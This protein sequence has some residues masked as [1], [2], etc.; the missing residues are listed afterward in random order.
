MKCVLS[1]SFQKSY[2]A[3]LTAREILE[4]AQIQ[5]LSP[6]NSE[7]TNPGDTFALLASDTTTDI[8]SLEQKHL[9]AISR[10]DFLYIYNP[11]GYIGT[12]TAMEIGWAY[13]LHKRIYCLTTPTDAM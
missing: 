9:D 8:L 3:M 13:A 2:E 6:S 10:A 12:S 5:V 4:K 11:E 1:G 7:I